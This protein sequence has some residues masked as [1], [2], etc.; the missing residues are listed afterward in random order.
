M[1][2]YGADGAIEYLGRKD[3]QVKLRGH[4]IELGEV[5]AALEE[6]ASVRQAIVEVREGAAGQK[7][8]LTYLVMKE[9][10]SAG[11]EELRGKLREKLPE[12]MIPRVYLRLSEFPLTRSGKVDRRNLPEPG[13][14]GLGPEHGYE[15]P[16][17]AEEEK[18]A[19]IW[20]QVLRIE[21]VGAHD[22]FFA[23]G[24]DSIL[25]I[26]VASKA[27]A[28]GINITVK[29]IAENP[30]IAQLA[31]AAQHIDQEL[32]IQPAFQLNYLGEIDKAKL[33]ELMAEINF[34]EE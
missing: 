20:S 5:E 21:R 22:N 2:R 23:L 11:D 28:R 13:R 17:T 7:Q 16:R 9:G 12:Y 25:S 27:I 32:S 18:L 3:R 19:S 29:Q 6:Q 30:T 1:G 10:A 15:E 4:R 14:D 8:L 31:A 26:R 33:N 34:E 24:G